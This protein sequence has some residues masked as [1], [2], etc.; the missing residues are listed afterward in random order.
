[1]DKKFIEAMN[2]YYKLKQQYDNDIE[3]QKKRILSNE[4][5]SKKEKQER[6]KQFKPKCINCKKLGGTIF[7]NTNFRLKA[8]CGSS[9]PCELNIELLKSPYLDARNEEMLYAKD[10]DILK[11]YI[12]MTKLDYLFG[13][14]SEE[15]TLSLFDSKNK[16]ISQVTQQLYKLKNY[17]TNIVNN[18]EDQF[19]LKKYENMYYNDINTLNNIYKEFEE[20]NKPEYIKDMVELYITKIKPVTD[21]IRNLKY[22]Y[23]GID[24][25]ED[26][27]TYT[28]I[29]EPYMI[30]DIE[31]SDGP[32]NTIISFV[33]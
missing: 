33:K 29:E 3:K 30:S 32:K 23:T 20:E 16:Q 17:I 27:D 2:Q 21:N 19:L 9:E 10:L 5:L 26:D 13:Y 12:I 14:K 31:Y 28:L 11:T 15:E 6:F 7:T 22:K 25:N 1:M 24:Y 8:V 18:K 4:S